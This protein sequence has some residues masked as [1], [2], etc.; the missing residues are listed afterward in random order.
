MK[1]YK[2]KDIMSKGFRMPT[3]REGLEA[4]YRTLAKTADQRMVRLEK[5]AASGGPFATVTKWAYARAARD[6]KHWSGQTEKSRWNTKTPRTIGGLESKIEDIKTFL[7]AKTS[8]KQGIKD[9]MNRTA[10]TNR[11][12]GTN[13]SWDN[14]GMF[15]SSKFYEELLKKYGSKVVTRAIAVIQ[16]NKNQIMTDI[17]NAQRSKI[18]APDKM[19]QSVVDDILKTFPKEVYD[20]LSEE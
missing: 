11:T 6:I 12:Y 7:S 5:L 3:D 10:E 2:Y 16:K 4:V 14:V 20:F 17:E 15:Y 9:Y 8:T 18:I 13:F 19:I 1:G